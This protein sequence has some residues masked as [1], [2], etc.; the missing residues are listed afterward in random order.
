MVYHH[1][2]QKNSFVLNIGSQTNSPFLFYLNLTP[3]KINQK[4]YEIFNNPN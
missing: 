3:Q 1:R 4:E 2:G